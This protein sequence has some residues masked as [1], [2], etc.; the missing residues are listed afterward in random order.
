MKSRYLLLLKMQ[1]YN[2]FGVN[3]M[4]HSHSKKEK[5]RSVAF[6]GVA[7]LIIGLMIVYSTMISMSL[8]SMGA[9]NILPTISVLICFFITLILTFLK[10]SGILIGL[11]DYDMVMSLPV[12][13][14]EVVLSRIT[15]VYLTNLLIGMI[16]ALPPVVIFGIHANAGPS[17]SAMFLLSL[18]F[19]PVI[20]M[21]IS[22]GIGVLISVI[23]S[24]SKHRN[25]FSLALSTLVVLLIVAASAGAQS[26]NADEILNIGILLSGMAKKLYPPAALISKAVEQQSW[27]RFFAFVGM[28]VFIGFVFVA[29]VAHFYQRM[30]TAAFRHSAIQYEGKGLKVSSPFKAMYRREFDR[31]FSCTIYALNSTVG[32]MLLLV[33]ALLFLFISPEALE[34]QSGIAGLGQMLRRVLP[35]VIA[36]FVAMTS[37]TSASLS[38]EGKNRWIMCSIPVRAM[39]IFNSKI[40]VNLTVICPFALAS[41]VLLGLKMEVSPTQAALLLIVPMAYACF[42]SVLGMYMNVK[43][44]K[45]DWTSEY[46]AVKGGAISVLATMGVGMLSSVVPLLCCIAFQDGSSLIMAAASILLSAASFML[47]GRLRRYRLYEII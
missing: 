30:N 19:L 8:A 18:L 45:Y 11:R 7:M 32:M 42:I 31:Y 40:A 28:S 41:A 15:M 3:R 13:N 10:S 33:V 9:A 36:V 5:Q 23:S 21:V 1:L 22:L 17:G 44:P 20:P 27:P 46:Y 35:L 29:V 47:Y 38:L 24:R 37:T 26:M 16:A 12:R 6:G 34:R 43:F 2:L 4:L 14:S 39:D 25:V